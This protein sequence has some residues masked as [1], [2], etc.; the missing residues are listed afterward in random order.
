MLA[1]D[2]AHVNHGRL[3]QEM[4]DEII[5]FLQ[6]DPITLRS[7]ALTHRSLLFASQKHIFNSLILDT[8]LGK[9][10]GSDEA[11]FKYFFIAPN[12]LRS[13]LQ[14]S[15]YIGAYVRNLRITTN[16]TCLMQS[17]EWE[18]GLTDKEMEQTHV[19]SLTFCLQQFRYL[20]CLS[21]RPALP[22]E[23]Y[24]LAWKNPEFL[25]AVQNL[26]SLPSLRCF[27]H[28][29]PM[30]LAY[31]LKN[32]IEYL[33]MYAETG[34]NL[35]TSATPQTNRRCSVDFLQIWHNDIY[36]STV[37]NPHLQEFLDIGNLKGLCIRSGH[38]RHLSADVDYL[39][40]ACEKSLLHLILES[41]TFLSDF[42]ADGL[43]FTFKN[44]HALHTFHVRLQGEMGRRLPML[45]TLLSTIPAGQE[46]MLEELVVQ[47]KCDYFQL[48]RDF[49]PEP[50]DNLWT[51]VTNS[52]H[53]PRLTKLYLR[54][55]YSM[56]FVEDP[57]NLAG[58]TYLLSK[59]HLPPDSRISLSVDVQEQV[60]PFGPF[61]LFW[62]SDRVHHLVRLF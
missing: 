22:E 32:H 40:R 53:F 25:Q 11:R 20:E 54:V 62:P 50:W 10:V 2:C 23:N 14:R 35:S 21:V 36:G 9:P 26:V 17:R 5:S 46:N 30:D 45:V 61:H 4:Y 33:S 12:Q 3:P 37:L 18:I 57:S 6:D 41:T 43:N 38:D 48:S 49:H 7:C 58:K 15:Q 1:P 28:C 39:L 24:K 29:S 52:T 16:L 44:L 34:P 27:D 8:G 59:W 47:I 56:G 31:N 13:I 55:F 51:L 19:E 60:N 42:D